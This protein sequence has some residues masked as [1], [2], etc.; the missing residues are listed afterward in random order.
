MKRDEYRDAVKNI[1]PGKRVFARVR[2]AYTNIFAVVG[3][4]RPESG[5]DLVL[6]IED[7]DKQ[8]IST[9]YRRVVSISEV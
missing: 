4:Y 7:K 3:R 2:G 6:R 9:P 1:K 5:A 8:L